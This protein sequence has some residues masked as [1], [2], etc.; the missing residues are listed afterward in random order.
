MAYSVEKLFS[1]NSARA[2]GK[3][4]LS[5]R[6]RIDDHSPAKGSSTPKK[7]VFITVDEFFNRIGRKRKVSRAY[8]MSDSI[9]SGW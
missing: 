4:D 2:I 7:E 3:V 9:L 8:P 1:L 5:D 6:S